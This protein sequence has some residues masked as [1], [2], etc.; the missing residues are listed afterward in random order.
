MREALR[1]RIGDHRPVVGT[2]FE[3]GIEHLD[4]ARLRIGSQLLAQALIRSHSACDHEPVRVT[5]RARGQT[6]GDQHVHRSCLERGR[7]IRRV[8]L[9]LLAHQRQHRGFQTAEAEIQSF[10]LRLAKFECFRISE[11]RMFINQR[12]ARI[13]KAE[14]LGAFVKRFTRGMLSFLF[15]P[16]KEG[17]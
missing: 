17:L 13:G 4:I 5:M 15:A 10:H 12:T 11:S 9:A 16:A 8:L 14:Q 1:T 7:N 2:K 6:F 3:R